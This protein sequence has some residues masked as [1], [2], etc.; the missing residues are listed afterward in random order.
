V[1]CVR[2]H[3]CPM[4]R[5]KWR[6]ELGVTVGPGQHSLLSASISKL[7]DSGVRSH[8]SNGGTSIAPWWR[9]VRRLDR[10]E[11]PDPVNEESHVFIAKPSKGL[12]GGCSPNGRLDLVSESISS[13]SKRTIRRHFDLHCL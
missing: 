11:S 12:K 6:T 4:T 3:F 2:E 10:D 8:L 5:R 13:V 9:D 7:G 1:G